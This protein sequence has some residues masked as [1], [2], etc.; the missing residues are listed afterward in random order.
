VRT[1]AVCLALALLA[2]LASGSQAPPAT[3]PAAAARRR[4]LTAELEELADLDLATDLV[5]RFLPHVDG[6][7][8]LAHDGSAIATVAR[9]LYATGDDAAALARLA[10]GLPRAT[11]GAPVDPAR[12]RLLIEEDR[13]AEALVTLAPSGRV[14]WPDEP[15]CWLLV[16]RALARRGDERAADEPARR[17]LAA[18]PLHPVAP[19]A[20]YLVGRAVLA[21]EDAD[22]GEEAAARAFARGRALE[23]WHALLRARR[24]QARLAPEDALPRVGLALLWLE[25]DRPESARAWAEDALRLA[26]ESD[27]ALLVAATCARR[28]GDA[29]RAEALCA[30]ALEQRPGWPEARLERAELF[31][32]SGRAEEGE[33]ELRALFEEGAE[34]GLPRAWLLLARVLLARGEREEA[35]R[36]YARYRQLGGAEPCGSIYRSR[37]A[38]IAFLS[39]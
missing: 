38:T 10:R 5:E 11:D 32:E 22:A 27:R 23:R 34:A 21:S 39:D 7:G 18:A 30:R 24:L 4:E 8:P 31:L 6:E 17:F 19:G 29:A 36:R 14:A 3:E 12:A 26:P 9:A 35:E 1:P 16:A 28:T 37:W 2:T 20:W 33:A 15:E 13:L 25:V